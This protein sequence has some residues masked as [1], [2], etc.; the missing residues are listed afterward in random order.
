MKKYLFVLIASLLLLS[1]SDNLNEAPVVKYENGK[2]IPIIDT[3][4]SNIGLIAPDTVWGD[5][6]YCA[7][8]Y[9]KN[10]NLRL[11]NSFVNCSDKGL[12]VDTTKKKLE[13]CLSELL[14][15]HDTTIFCLTPYDTTLNFEYRIMF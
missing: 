2:Q 13:T 6:E 10:S 12:L 9:L 3:L 14:V 15:E 8:M 5:E 1:C 11:V 4:D 7:K